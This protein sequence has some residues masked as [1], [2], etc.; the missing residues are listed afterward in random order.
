VGHMDDSEKRWKCSRALERPQEDGYIC[1]PQSIMG[2]YERRAVEGSKHEVVR[3]K[4]RTEMASHDW[5]SY[6]DTVRFM[7]Q[8][9]QRGDK[10]I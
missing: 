9:R 6:N 7:A 1:A 4:G 3:R 10:Y 2:S 5:S 8:L